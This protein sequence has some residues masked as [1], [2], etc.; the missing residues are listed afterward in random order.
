MRLRS[1][2]VWTRWVELT[3]LP[4]PRLSIWIYGVQ[5]AVLLQGGNWTEGNA[6]REAKRGVW[7]EKRL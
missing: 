2:S 5:Y 6:E 1:G 3:A 7:G 4:R